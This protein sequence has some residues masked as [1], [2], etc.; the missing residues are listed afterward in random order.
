MS[1]NTVATPAVETIVETTTSTLPEPPAMHSAGAEAPRE[2]RISKTE[3][4]ELDSH[5]KLREDFASAFAA[6]ETSDHPL[7]SAASKTLASKRDRIGSRLHIAAEKLRK[8]GYTLR[9]DDSAPVKS[10][11]PAAPATKPAAP[12]VETPAVDPATLVAEV[13]TATELEGVSVEARQG[14]KRH[15][16]LIT[17]DH[18][19]RLLAY[20]DPLKRGSGFRVE[21]ANYGAYKTATVTTVAAAAKLVAASERVAP[22]VSAAAERKLAAE[23]AKLTAALDELVAK[24]TAIAEALPVADEPVAEPVVVTDAPVAS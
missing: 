11:A 14:G 6:F 17:D 7:E 8:R 18:S 3:Q 22:K 20:V 23:K 19:T 2:A 4:R 24:T 1:E 9:H 15:V 16:V 10:D 12:V 21:V 13:A 5:A